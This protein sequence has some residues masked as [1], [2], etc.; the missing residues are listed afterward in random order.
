YLVLN[1]RRRP[2]CRHCGLY[3]PIERRQGPPIAVLLFNERDEVLHDGYSFRG[4]M[5]TP[6][7]APFRAAGVRKVRANV[8]VVKPFREH[9]Q[10]GAA[11][12]DVLIR[13]HMAIDAPYVRVHS[14]TR[15][16]PLIRKGRVVGV[17]T[18]LMAVEAEQ[19]FRL[20]AIG[21]LSGAQS[22]I[23]SRIVVA[24]PEIDGDRAAVQSSR[25]QRAD[26]RDDVV[27]RMTRCTRYSLESL[28]RNRG[29]IDNGSGV[30]ACAR[31]S[32]KGRMTLC[33][34]PVLGRD[35]IGLRV[36]RGEPS[37]TRQLPCVPASACPFPCT[38]RIWSS[39]NCGAGGAGRAGSVDSGFGLKPNAQ[40]T[41]RVVE[42]GEVAFR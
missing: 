29:G 10:A 2:V 36:P 37:A 27:R 24:L 21:A 13:R 42:A 17:V 30:E 25:I 19:V 1:E 18:L 12:A 5:M 31:G 20:S 28:L 41:R 26:L 34:K 11:A 8:P 4:M 35:I 6:C 33:A 14:T 3:H 7:P 39:T 40:Y 9:R 22:L 15:V 32:L 23:G 16:G 38:A